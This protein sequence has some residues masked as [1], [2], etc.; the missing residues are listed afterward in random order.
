MDGVIGSTAARVESFDAHA[1]LDE[2]RSHIDSGA[3]RLA[4]RWAEADRPF[5]EELAALAVAYFDDLNDGVTPSA[6]HGADVTRQALAQLAVD[7]SSVRPRHRA[8]STPAQV[9]QTT[10]ESVGETARQF[11]KAIGKGIRSG[12]LEA[13]SDLS[14]VARAITDERIATLEALN[15]VAQLSPREILEA[16]TVRLTFDKACELHDPKLSVFSA[17]AFGDAIENHPS[18]PANFLERSLQV[19]ADLRGDTEF[20]LVT[21]AELRDYVLSH[22]KDP[23]SAVAAL[24]LEVETLSADP[25]FALLGT[26][27]I[28]FAAAKTADPRAHL[29]QISKTIEDVSAD[30]RIAALGAG[31]IK[32]VS[33]KGLKTAKDRL[34]AV[35]DALERLTGDPKY[36]N[37]WE[38]ERIRA[39][40]SYPAD[41]EGFLDTFWNR[42]QTARE[43]PR[44]TVFADSDIR[45][46]ALHN[47]DPVETLK[48]A[49]ESLVELVQ[50]DRYFALG[51]LMLTHAVLKYPG[52]TEKWLDD[53]IDVIDTLALDPRCDSYKRSTIVHAVLKGAKTV[54]DL[55]ARAS[56]RRF[57]TK[58]SFRL[59]ELLADDIAAQ[60]AASADQSGADVTFRG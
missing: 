8:P 10:R 57:A 26:S 7:V 21:D 12:L 37:F 45:D 17:T 41:P 33:A 43:D 27:L 22:P 58:A 47:D 51:D 39:A 6:A 38:S 55:P 9:I 49:R 1:Y 13:P 28:K 5:G 16:N 52:G 36:A 25:E 30:A 20:E 18:A 4:A 2:V 50:V 24:K 44:L 11:A 3:I 14:S 59:R 19:V 42:Y 23:T 46:I 31:V 40:V 35:A 53:M 32:H 48:R 15:E 60:Q 54:E 34:G 29:R 56:D